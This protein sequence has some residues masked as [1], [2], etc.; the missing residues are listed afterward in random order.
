M[1][2]FLKAAQL[3]SYMRKRKERIQ[4]VGPLPSCANITVRKP[5]TALKKTVARHPPSKKGK[6]SSA[7]SCN[8]YPE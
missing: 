3:F 7:A 1:F 2:I 8:I 5:H 6:P 4:L